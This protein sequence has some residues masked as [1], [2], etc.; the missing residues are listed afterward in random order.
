MADTKRT[1]TAILALLADNSSGAISPQDLRDSV[2]SARANQGD[3]WDFLTETD[4]SEGA[5]QVISASTRTK[6]ECDGAGSLSVSTRRTDIG[7]A[8]WDGTNHKFIPELGSAYI[9]RL[10][11]K[12]KTSSGAQDKYVET[13]LDIGSGGLGTGPVIWADIN[14]LVKGAGVEHSFQFAIPLFAEDPF[15]TN[16]GTFYVESNVDITVWDVR[17]FFA[18]IFKLDT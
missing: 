13:Q 11:Y 9:F 2:V 7:T 16:G 4:R 12:C 10:T 8:T 6:L 5:A 3:G 17:V 14:P 15:P 1:Q 18:R